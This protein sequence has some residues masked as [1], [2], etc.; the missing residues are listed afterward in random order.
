[1]EALR[2]LVEDVGDPVH[3]ASLLLSLRPHV[4]QSGPEP[5]CAVAHGHDGGAHS[6]ALEAAQE[7]SPALRALPVAILDGDQLLRSVR[8]DAD[9]HERAEAIL[10][11]AVRKWTPSAHT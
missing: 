7:T 1:M 5:E 4:S 9:Q 3:P 8:A 2:E 11:Q 6:S 10:F